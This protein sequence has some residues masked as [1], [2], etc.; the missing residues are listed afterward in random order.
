MWRF[1]G[2]IILGAVVV[3]KRHDYYN[4][5]YSRQKQEN[6]RYYSFI[7]KKKL[8]DEFREYKENPPKN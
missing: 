4:N 2:G 6:A 7:L 5:I 1:C 3:N 8:Q